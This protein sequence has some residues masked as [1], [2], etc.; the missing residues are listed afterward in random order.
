MNRI[1]I[2][3]DGVLAD[4]ERLKIEREVTGEDLKQMPG[5]FRHMEPIEGAIAGVQSLIGMG[6][7]CWI[8]TKPPTGIPH[9][10]A[11]KAQ[12]I[13][14]HLPELKRRIIMTHEKGLL[15]DEH[16]YLIDDRPHKA[17]CEEF[18][19]TLVRFRCTDEF[20]DWETVIG[21]FRGRPT[22]NGH[23]RHGPMRQSAPAIAPKRK[24]N[25]IGAPACFAL[26]QA[27]QHIGAAFGDYGIYQVG[28]SLERADWRDVDLRYI[29]PDDE[30]A[31]LFPDAGDYWE[32]DPRWL[33]L[34]VSI[35]A[36]LSKQTGLPVDFQ[37]QPQTHA[38]E[39]HKGNRNAMGI[40][41][42]KQVAAGKDDE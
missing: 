34:T 6:F 23:R 37:F 5:A 1:F 13:C 30:F 4:F 33:L 41:I 15:G 11:D 24:S 8:A 38:N 27:C 22:P 21:F 42:L 31:K 18:R 36:W 26:E 3:M 10:Y 7:E 25:Y 28:S 29:L 40:R 14:T 32:H 12:W 20:P 17:N 9:A 19:G 35:S 16:D 2:D 39:R